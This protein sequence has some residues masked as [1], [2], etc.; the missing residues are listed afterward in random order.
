VAD[1]GVP[2]ENEGGTHGKTNL[3]VRACCPQRLS[4]IYGEAKEKAQEKG[5]DF[6]ET[7]LQ[8][9]FEDIS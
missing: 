2:Q 3:K 4:F 7:D 6:K 8:M 1:E 5:K 9:A